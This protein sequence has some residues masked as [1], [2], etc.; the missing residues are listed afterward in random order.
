MQRLQSYKFELMPID[1]Q[2]RYMRRYAGAWN[3]VSIAL[4]RISKQ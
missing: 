2:E 3:Q 1:E 4:A